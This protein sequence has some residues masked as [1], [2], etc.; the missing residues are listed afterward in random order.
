MRSATRRRASPRQ[1]YTPAF[2]EPETTR[3]WPCRRDAPRTCR[4]FLFLCPGYWA[5]NRPIAERVPRTKESDDKSSHSKGAVAAFSLAPPS[6]VP[7]RVRSS[8]DPREVE[9][10]RAPRPRTP[11]TRTKRTIDRT[12]KSVSRTEEVLR[13]SNVNVCGAFTFFNSIV[14]RFPSEKTNVAFRRPLPSLPSE[15]SVITTL[16]TWTERPKSTCHQGRWLSDSLA[17]GHRQP[18]AWSV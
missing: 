7:F 3:G 2:S 15:R 18:I 17:D 8:R 14:C 5:A 9:C 11:L 10:G 16:S 12:T 13:T 6:G 4:R 1:R